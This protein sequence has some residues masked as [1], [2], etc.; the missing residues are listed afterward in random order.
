MF[1]LEIDRVKKEV[2]IDLEPDAVLSARRDDP[3]ALLQ[4]RCHR[5]LEA[6]GSWFR[7]STGD[8]VDSVQIVWR[9]DL[10]NVELLR[11]KHLLVIAIIVCL[12]QF[13]TLP[14]LAGSILI[15]IAH[16]HNLGIA[17]VQVS[18]DILIADGPQADESDLQLHGACPVVGQ[19][20][21][22]DAAGRD[23]EQGHTDHIFHREHDASTLIGYFPATAAG[24]ARFYH[25]GGP[26]QDALPLQQRVR[27]ASIVPLMLACGIAICHDVRERNLATPPR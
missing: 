9:E 4:G 7:F 24:R 19:P 27:G 5:L 15:G 18:Q 16:R 13:P 25:C 10:D 20:A 17:N 12:R 26:P 8:G 21:A 2:L 6:D 22:N 1:R 14:P 23:G 3:I 11:G